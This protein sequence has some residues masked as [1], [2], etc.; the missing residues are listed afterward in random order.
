[1]TILLTSFSESESEIR[2]IR[3]AVFEDEQHVPPGIDWDGND[4][5]CLHALALGDNGEAVATGRLAPDGKIGRLAVLSAQRGRGFGTSLLR[6]LVGAAWKQGLPKVFLH[7]QAQALKFYEQAGF[8][9]SGESFDEAEIEHFYMS[10][11][12]SDNEGSAWG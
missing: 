5:K 7:A 11:S 10:R 3:N 8:Q 12:L 2:R 6:A 1:M 4:S 9:V